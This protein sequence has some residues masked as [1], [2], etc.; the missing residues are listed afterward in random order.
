MH[1]S[2]GMKAAIIKRIIPPNEESVAAV[3]QETGVSANTLYNWKKQASEG[4]LD[5]DTSATRPNDRN[6]GEK[7]TLLL[8]SRGLTVEDR[9]EWLRS[10]GLHS[11]HLP[12]WEQELRDLVTDKEKLQRKENTDLKRKNKQLQRELARKEKAL[13][14]MAA[15][16]TLKKKADAIW[17]DDE[18]V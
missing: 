7:L 11:E 2:S 4:M 1:Y 13:A 10:R 16:L 5:L 9:G 6:P 3:S 8:E 18:D 14:E 12:Q 15:L 17:G